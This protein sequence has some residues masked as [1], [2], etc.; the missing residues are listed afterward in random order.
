MIAFEE[1]F[2]LLIFFR[3]WI[4]VRVLPVDVQDGKSAAVS[5]LSD[6]QEKSTLFESMDYSV[7]YFVNFFA[8]TLISQHHNR[9]YE[10]NLG[11]CLDIVS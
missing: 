10:E 5:N 6:S 4:G 8:P 11:V 2:C 1:F 7:T 9:H 3:N